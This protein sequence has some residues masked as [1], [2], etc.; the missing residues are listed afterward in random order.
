MRIIFQNDQVVEIETN[1]TTMALAYKK[2]LTHLQHIPLQYRDWDNPYFLEEVELPQLVDQLVYYGNLV[3]IAVDKNRFLQQS[4]EYSNHMHMLFE[5]NYDGNPD[6][7]KFHETLHLCESH[8]QKNKKFFALDY[9]EK[10]GLLIKP[11]D[12]E[13]FKHTQTFVSAGDVY[14]TW[15]ELGKH[16]YMYWRDHEPNNLK[17]LCELAKPWINFI[18]TLRIALDNIDSL[19]FTDIDEFNSWW[20]NY[21]KDWCQHWHIKAWKLHDMFG[22]VVIGRTNNV[23]ILIN[24]AKQKVAPVYIKL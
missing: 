17:R 11:I 16:P 9:R 10:A 8:T 23:D 21:E 22:K 20:S 4:Q 13:F 19:P 2:I 12:P 6:W 15:A 24:L 18:P 14:L 5:K 7:L 1:S 3:A